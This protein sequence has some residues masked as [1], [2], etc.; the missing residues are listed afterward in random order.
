MGKHY[1]CVRLCLEDGG[2]HDDAKKK[3]KKEEE[4]KKWLDLYVYIYNTI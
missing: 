1:E 3:K 2:W 4:K